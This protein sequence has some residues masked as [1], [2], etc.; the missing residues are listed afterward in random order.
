MVTRPAG[1]VGRE[2]T[3][4][5]ASVS[6]AV[7]STRAGATG[8]VEDSPGGALPGGLPGAAVDP[9]E[10]PGPTVEG[11]VAQGELEPGPL[12]VLFGLADFGVRRRS[13][14]RSDLLRERPGGHLRCLVRWHARGRELRWPRACPGAATAPAPDA[15]HTRQSK[16]RMST[17][18]AA[19]RTLT[20]PAQAVQ[21]TRLRE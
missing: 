16:P 2:R 18:L 12:E 21:T 13:W 15:P 6:A 10:E 17:E 3:K 9:G 5:K 7:T 11:T 1:T 4:R 14:L 8:L 20:S 19:P